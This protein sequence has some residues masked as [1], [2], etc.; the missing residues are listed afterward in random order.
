MPAARQ[1][2]LSPIAVAVVCV[3][4]WALAGCSVGLGQLP[5][6]APGTGGDG[7]VVTAIFRNALNLPAK[8]KVRVKGADVG[9]VLDM[10]VR[11]YLAV[12]RMQ[13]RDGTL[14][15][16][17]TRAEL[18][19]ATP[20]GDVFVALEPPADPGGA[21]LQD[22]DTIPVEST[23]AGATVEEVL[24][25]AAM[26]VNGGAIRNLTKLVNGLGESVGDG[27]DELGA[28]VREST[29]LVASLSA[30]TSEIEAVLGSANALAD[31]VV[32]RQQSIDSALAAAGPALGVVADNTQAI[33]GTVDQLTRITQQLERFPS[34]N[35]TGAGGMV[36]DINRIAGWLN[37]A[38][39]APG[40]SI[41]D[42][43][44]I[45]GP[46][47]KLTSGT[48]GHVD[49]S[50][51]QFALGAF[52]DPNYHADP[53]SRLPDA[54]DWERFAGSLAVTMFRL[55]QRLEGPR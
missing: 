16:Q 10:E 12:V 28:L 2:R 41:E 23:S 40:A 50:I 47:I 26:L 43:N 39:T 54:G 25:T 18:R 4:C 3:L 44:R 11:D 13:L 34:I 35:G 5:L 1:S 51:S 36:Q 21:V 7:F 49:V 55:Q 53:G 46:I 24:S 9:F 15:P 32:E 42:V 8:A 22:G 6:P 30:R 17:G 33:L 14:L 37:A 48:S 52:D 27:G 45:L 29:T 31:T 38:A 20:L 19:S